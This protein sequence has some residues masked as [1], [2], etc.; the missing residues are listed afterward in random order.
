VFGNASLDYTFDKM[1]MSVFVNAR[2]EYLDSSIATGL[3]E[4]GAY[5]VYGFSMNYRLNKK[6]TIGVNLDNMLGKRFEDS[7]GFLNEEVRLRFN[8]DY[9]L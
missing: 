1:S 8:L 7:V 6:A 9:R 2:D 3:V 5:A 4:L